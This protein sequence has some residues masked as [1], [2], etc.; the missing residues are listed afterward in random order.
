MK[1]ISNK[2]M[3]N[4]CTYMNDDIREELHFKL[5]P[6][7]NKTFLNEYCKR[8]PGFEELLKN[9]FDIVL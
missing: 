6:C 8:D 7:S 5:V 9:E 1:K 2:M 4:I 3:E